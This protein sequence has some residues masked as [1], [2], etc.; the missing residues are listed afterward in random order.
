M[1]RGL[2]ALALSLA[3]L[4]PAAAADTLSIALPPDLGTLPPGPGH[5][6]TVRACQMCHSLD[7]I[8]IQPPGAEAQWRGVVT[9]MITVYGAPI[10]DDDVSAIVRYLA[11]HFGPA[12]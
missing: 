10:G 1:T 4:A 5:D 2:L 6:A 11:T 7:Y 3:V 9:K 12:P 8:T